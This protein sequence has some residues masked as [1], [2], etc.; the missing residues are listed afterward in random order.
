MPKRRTYSAEYRLRIL[1]QADACSKP[2]EIGVLL[3]REGLY[4]S[5][6]TEWRKLREKGALAGLSKKRGRKSRPVD[7]SAKRVAE[8]ER[9]NE[10]LSKSLS[11]A[12]AII[13]IQKKLSELLGVPLPNAKN[14]GKA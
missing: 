2:G 14:S 11:Q 9:E 7:P 13:D 12:E 10:R 1:E 5:H 4:S 8:L 6:L 3:R